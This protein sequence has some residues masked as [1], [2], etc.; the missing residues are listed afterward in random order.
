MYYVHD[1]LVVLSGM[2][3]MLIIQYNL[4][5]KA[6]PLAI[7]MLSS[8]TVDLRQ[9]VPLKY[10]TCCQEYVVFQDRWS[11]MA[12]VSQDRFHCCSRTNV[13]TRLLQID[14]RVRS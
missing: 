12:V 2:L 5:Q 11:V 8:M 14:V 10:K 6:A 4:S 7:K 9:Q 3:R 1:I 13:L